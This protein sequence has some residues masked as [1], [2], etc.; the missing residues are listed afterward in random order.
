MNWNYLQN[1][2][3]EFRWANLVYFL[4]LFGPLYFVVSLWIVQYSEVIAS[5]FP[6]VTVSF[7][8]F[9]WIIFVILCDL[10]M[11]IRSLAWELWRPKWKTACFDQA[12]GLKATS[13]KVRR[14]RV[15]RNQPVSVFF[16]VTAMT[17]QWI[18]RE[19]SSVIDA[20]VWI[21]VLLT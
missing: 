2:N 15:C 17:N 7:S 5:S 21:F 10:G 16:P 8:S 20:V 9:C 14:K 11:R 1:D 19:G 4:L 6:P 18:E 13:T 3:T 12:I